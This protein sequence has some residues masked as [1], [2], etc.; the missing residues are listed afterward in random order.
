MP[1]R[2]VSVN[3]Q[4]VP[5]SSGSVKW[6]SNVEVMNSKTAATLEYNPINRSVIV[7]VNMVGG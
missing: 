6:T 2:V 1:K 7:A 3:V 4:R 5:S